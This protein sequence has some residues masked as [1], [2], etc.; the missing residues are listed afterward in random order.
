MERVGIKKR[1]RGRERTVFWLVRDRSEERM[2]HIKS[3]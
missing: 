2:R 1:E 3:K